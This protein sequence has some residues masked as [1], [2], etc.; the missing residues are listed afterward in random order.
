MVKIRDGQTRNQPIYTTIGVD[1]D[2]H[3]DILGIRAD[4]EGESAKL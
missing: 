1:L 3:K 2:N 4:N